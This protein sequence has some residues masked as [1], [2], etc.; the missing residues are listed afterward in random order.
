MERDDRTLCHR[1]ALSDKAG[2]AVFNSNL[3][4]A[5]NSLLPTDE[6]GAGFF[7]AGLLDTTSQIEVGTTTI[8]EFC[9]QERIPRVD[10][11]KLDAQGA[12]FAILQG[13]KSMLANGAISLVYTELIMVPTYKGQHKLHEYL[14]FLEA[15]DYNLLD[16]FNP[17]RSR[18]QLI[19]A[20]ALFS[21]PGLVAAHVGP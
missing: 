7:G 18:N 8:D 20:D 2:T 11:L 9:L 19:Q 12:E 6:R 13:A 14:S 5:T 10:I 1:V 16:F 15:F 21:S 17:E 3:S 4:A